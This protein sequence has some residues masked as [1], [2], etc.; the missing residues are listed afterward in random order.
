MTAK[1]LV[2]DKTTGATI[3]GCDNL[4]EAITLVAELLREGRHVGVVNTIKSKEDT[5]KQ[6]YKKQVH[7]KKHKT[8]SSDAVYIGRPSKWGNPFVIGKD[9]NRE[10]VIAKFEEWILGQP[11]LLADLHEI[12]GKDLVCWCAPEACHGDV[13]ARLANNDSQSQEETMNKPLYK[14]AFTGHR[15]PKI[16]GY[17]DKNPLRVA[18]K[19]AIGAVLDRAVAKYGKTHQ[20]VIISGGALGVDQDAARVAHKMGLP[21]IVA[22]P[23]RN[24]DSKW[25]KQSQERYKKMLGL[26]MDVVYVHD[27][28]YRDGCL[29]KRNEWMIN[30]CDALVAVWDGSPGGTAHCVKYARSAG[31]PIV[32]VNPNNLKEVK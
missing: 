16:G 4:S 31:K 27:G 10:Q 5:M 21:F 24:Q 9:G 11:Q 22:A 26:A 2:V 25:P 1:Y 28:P 3:Q 30:H 18:V 20:I 8:A 23:C 12:K 14:I 29:N 15:P 19:D 6:V 17:D 13:L 7:N 32:M